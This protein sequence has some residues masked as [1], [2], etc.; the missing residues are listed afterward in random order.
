L[1]L[2]LA[3]FAC[4]FYL[5]YSG[6]FNPRNA[7]TRYRHWVFIG[8]GFAAAVCLALTNFGHPT[9]MVN[10]SQ[11]SLKAAEVGL[12]NFYQSIWADYP[13]GYIY[14]LYLVG[15]LAGLLGLGSGHPVFVLLL[16]LPAILCD[17]AIGY[18]I[19][20]AARETL[21]TKSAAN[22]CAF[23]VLN[24]MVLLDSAVWGQVDSVLALITVLMLWCYTQ[25][26]KPMVAALFVL[27]VL[28]K[29]QMLMFG[30]LM[31]VAYLYDIRVDW[32]KG[33][34]SFFTSLLA[35]I[36]VLVA[37]IFPFSIHQSSPFWIVQKYIDAAN[38][39]PMATINGFNLYA[40][41]GK[42]WA[43]DTEFI[44]AGISYKNFGLICIALV[45][46]GA[47]I[48]YL[49]KKDRK[50]VFPIA[51][52]VV[53]GVYA[54]G[55]NMHDRYLFPAIPLFLIAYTIY[56]RRGLLYSGA[57][58][59][60]VVLANAVISY[61]FP[62]VHLP[63][64]PVSIVSIVNLMGFVYAAA[65]VINALFG[66]GD[67]FLLDAATVADMPADEKPTPGGG[68]PSPNH[69][70][71]Q[72]HFT[73][74]PLEQ[75]QENM[76]KEYTAPAES[77]LTRRKRG[78]MNRWDYLII[79]L[80]VAVYASLS[81][82][83]LGGLSVPESYFRSKVSGETYLVD[84]GEEKDIASLYYYP[85]INKGSLEVYTS[86]DN[87]TFDRLGTIE[88]KHSDMYQWAH[89]NLST[90][91]R[92][93]KFVTAT[94]GVF[95]NEMG[96]YD[97]AG[98]LVQVDSATAVS[99]VPT[100]DIQKLFDEP[101][102]I[103]ESPSFYTEMYFDEIYHA[104]AAFEQLNGMPVYETVH[105][106][107][108]KMLI[109]AGIAIFGMNPFGWRV[110]GA[111]FGIFSVPLFYILA[112]RIFKR[113]GLA[114]F[115]TLLWAADGMLFVQSRIATLDV[116]IT[117]FILLMVYFMYRYWEMDFFTDGLSATL[118][119]LGLCG[120][121]FGLGVATKW[122]GLYCGA[123]LAIVFFISLFHRYKEYKLAKA[124]LLL[125]K[126]NYTLQQEIMVETFYGNV[127]KN[128]LFC[129]IYF[130]VLPI[131]IYLSAYLQ[132][133]FSKEDPFTFQKILTQN[134]NMF[135]YHSALTATHPFQSMWYT[136]P[137]IDRPIF[138]YSGEHAPVGTIESIASFGNPIVWW[139]GLAAALYCLV[140]VWI[141]K[142]E[143]KTN[144]GFLLIL[145]LSVYVPWMFITRA[146]FIYHYMAS[147]PFI[148]LLIGCVVKGWEDKGFP[149]WIKWIISVVCLGVFALFYPVWSA[150]PVDRNWA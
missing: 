43:A 137:V 62:S 126:G 56:R 107:L 113:T 44:F 25:N 123:G 12:P 79:T 18:F 17:A 100:G 48:L 33:L 15:K 77:P 85:G 22:L 105:P 80:L 8:I 28:V 115:T 86:V 74:E 13:P 147:V 1:I 134:V 32:R 120:I 55:P 50:A 150:L 21:G 51:A 10:F 89:F 101:Q 131:V 6:V 3:L 141:R 78:K 143:D 103:D 119:P 81:F 92:Y 128:L 37:I 11:W 72:Q 127:I 65:A 88:T 145:L 91:A 31:L 73:E 30:P 76:E 95:L 84:L 60:V 99:K 102:L 64:V 16:K 52:L 125:G 4:L 24:P 98:N 109:S 69:Q 149:K 90:T 82:W 49:R 46:I 87:A 27:G 38:L 42:N 83:R 59:T 133:M 39:Y 97:T 135:S 96:I 112:K 20:R 118:V 67:G 35:G 58:A 68:Q 45:C 7:F 114:A 139:L 104:R 14:V 40:L 63:Q 93:L 70:E 66:K 108:G 110:M 75:P 132:H 26:R 144:T 57:L 71:T 129:C 140:T 23:Y 130:I 122:I 29:P 47:A 53:W 148:I 136:W 124:A 117:F 36:L 54:F 34:L 121:S 106:P 138:Y 146:V 41:L 111:L 9:D 142:G 19:Y 116:F 5:I 61:L 94:P 2:I